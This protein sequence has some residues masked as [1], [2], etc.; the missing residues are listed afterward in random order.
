MDI[1]LINQKN[2]Y[3]VF[4]KNKTSNYCTKNLLEIGCEDVYLDY[5]LIVENKYD[6]DILNYKI[7]TKKTPLNEIFILNTKSYRGGEIGLLVMKIIILLISI[8]NILS[9]W[10]ESTGSDC[11]DC[12]GN[13]IIFFCGFIITL[14]LFI[15]WLVELI[16]FSVSCSKYNND[17]AQKYLDFLNCP[18]V[19]KKG[20]VKFNSIDD[21]YTHLIIFMTF[22]IIYIICLFLHLLIVILRSCCQNQI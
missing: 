14:I 7:I 13:C 15:L 8:L 16:I 18:N 4:V 1:S 20:F 3:I 11:A 2:L 6:C 21:L 12:L 22:N 10:G 5:P 19:D 17:D 9:I